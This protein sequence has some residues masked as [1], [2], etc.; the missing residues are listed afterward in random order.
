MPIDTDALS[1]IRV[2]V[3]LADA[4]QGT[5]LAHAL[6]EYDFDVLVAHHIRS[7]MRVMKKESPQAVIVEV[8]TPAYDGF[9]VAQ[10]AQGRI[11]AIFLVAGRQLTMMEDVEVLTSGAKE[12]F[13]TPL[14]SETIAA[15]IRAACSSNAQDASEAENA[16]PRTQHSSPSQQ[17]ESHVAHTVRAV[18]IIDAS[19]KTE[20]ISAVKP[21]DLAG[22]NDTITDASVIPINPADFAP[23]LAQGQYA[24]RPDPA[25]SPPADVPGQEA[26]PEVARVKNEASEPVAPFADD[27]SSALVADLFDA[28]LGPTVIDP[29]AVESPM[30][31]RTAHRQEVPRSPQTTDTAPLQPITPPEPTALSPVIAS[32]DTDDNTSAALVDDLFGPPPE[33]KVASSPS[34]T[35]SSKRNVEAPPED[36]FLMAGM[37]DDL[38]G[39]SPDSVR[40]VQPVDPAV[41]EEQP[42]EDAAPLSPA[43]VDEQSLPTEVAD[44]PATVDLIAAAYGT[45]STPK[46]AAY[47]LLA[48]VV[49]AS[50]WVGSLAMERVAPSSEPSL[51]AEEAAQAE[52]EAEARERLHSTLGEA[53]INHRAGDLEKAKASY[54]DALV[55]DESN[56]VALRG[57]IGI[58]LHKADWAAARRSLNELAQVAPDDASLP[59]QQALVLNKLNK[60]PGALAEFL[61]FI[62]ST[63]PDDPRLRPAAQA[64]LSLTDASAP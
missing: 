30:M 47:G 54:A 42:T 51:T 44:G 33:G 25:P 57:L 63:E 13:Y 39:L 3:C 29:S 27:T 60:R 46:W 5:A 11:R 26:T 37:M 48:A 10:W 24:R 4:D 55:Q 17:M 64:Y 15:S 28:P 23:T 36:E 14:Q 35:P 58:A 45:S 22:V 16:D 31:A 12:L 19:A 53:A 32:T 59:L 40:G 49:C 56:D 1:R 8:A 43:D 18:S 52:A 9:R 61:R 6:R 41:E 62:D 38:D 7:A 34:D 2:L 21:S 20:A 50:G